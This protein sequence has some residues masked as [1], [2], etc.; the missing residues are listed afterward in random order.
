MKAFDQ[1]DVDALPGLKI[2]LKSPSLIEKLPYLSHKIYR[3]HDENLVTHP[4][5]S[6]AFHRP[7]GSICFFVSRGKQPLPYGAP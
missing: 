4:S 1:V 3:C 2:F 5:F 7:C 6:Y